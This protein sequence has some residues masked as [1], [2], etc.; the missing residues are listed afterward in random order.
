MRVASALVTVVFVLL[1][2]RSAAANAAA[3]FY[4]QADSAG[5]LVMDNQGEG[6]RVE[7]E[8]LDLRCHEDYAHFGACTFTATYDL[9]NDTDDAVTAR[10]AFYGIDAGDSAKVTLDGREL[11]ELRDQEARA[12]IDATYKQNLERALIEDGPRHSEGRKVATFELTMAARGR[13]ALTF[14]GVL[15]AV[16]KDWDRDAYQASGLMTRH[17]YFVKENGKTTGHYRYLVFPIRAWR[18]DP[19]IDVSVRT[20]SSLELYGAAPPGEGV[21]PSERPEKPVAWTTDDAGVHRARFRAS[22]VSILDWTVVLPSP[23]FIPGGPTLGIGGRLDK[24]ELRMRVGVE[25]SIVSTSFIEGLHFETD[26][27]KQWTLV[28]SIDAATPD[29]FIIIPSAGVGAGVPI[30]VES[31]QPVRVGGRLQATLHF[32][33]L[34]VVFP[35]DYY[36]SGNIWDLSLMARVSL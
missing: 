23:R 4:R 31:G 15:H 19:V 28:P 24:P 21:S 9:V 30:R 14:T 5:A 1:L 27:S 8:S 36:P 33:L 10:G 13:G 6:L 16:A 34:G 26:A 2:A 18:G 25:A 29:I 12:S 22:E 11:P 7:H 3:N 32:P 17:V 35:I 20:D